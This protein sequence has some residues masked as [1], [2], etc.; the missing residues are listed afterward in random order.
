MHLAASRNLN[1]WLSGQLL[2]RLSNLSTCVG[3]NSFSPTAVCLLRLN[4][5]HPRG[6]DYV[7]E[8]PAHRPTWPERCSLYANRHPGCLL[9]CRYIQ[10]HQGQGIA[11]MERNNRMASLCFIR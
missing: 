3:S 4:T 2:L 10:V 9:F 8:S 6:N 7:S 5:L 11:A 1:T